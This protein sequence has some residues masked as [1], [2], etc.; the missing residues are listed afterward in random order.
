VGGE[1]FAVDASLIKAD[2]NRQKSYP[3]SQGLPPE[4]A[5]RA[6]DEYLAVLDDAAFGGATEVVP[7]FISPSDPASRW[8]GAHR[9]PAFFAYATNY[10]IDL[11]HGVIVDVEASVPIRQAE[12]GASRTMLVR[13]ADRF[14]LCPNRLVADT[15]YGSADNLGWLVHDQAIEPHIPVFEKGERSDGTFSKSDFVFDNESD[16]YTCPGGKPLQQYHR[17]YTVPREMAVDKHGFI[18]YRASKKDCDACAALRQNVAPIRP[19]GR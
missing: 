5:S 1:G 8:T 15:A 18:R 9:G 3:A 14:G 11:D 2:A 7:K 4:L 13:T 17:D 12:V 19:Q 6:I 16:S 10:L